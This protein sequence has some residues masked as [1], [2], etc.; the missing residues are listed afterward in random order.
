M[1]EENAAGEGGRQP[2]IGLKISFWFHFTKEL[3]EHNEIYLL[4]V[5]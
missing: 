4:M 3:T 5:T 2:V 1:Q